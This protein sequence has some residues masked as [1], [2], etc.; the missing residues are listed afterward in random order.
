MGDDG[1]VL[2]PNEFNG[3]SFF[4]IFNTTGALL[5]N[6]PGDGVE[7]YGVALLSDRTVVAAN[8]YGR[9]VSRFTP[10][11]ALLP[12]FFTGGAR[13]AHPA[14]DGTDKIDVSDDEGDLVRT[15]S[16]SRGTSTTTGCSCS[17]TRPSC[18]RGTRAGGV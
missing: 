8:D 17:S 10:S 3:L 15:D 9:E 18:P 5:G 16:C 1:R 11:G 4:R 13:A 14:V 2:V 7:S 6:A 12:T